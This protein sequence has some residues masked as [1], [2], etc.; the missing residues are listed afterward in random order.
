MNELFKPL[1]MHPDAIKR[2]KAMKK[3]SDEIAELN[4]QIQAATYRFLLLI[5]EYDERGYWNDGGTR[6]CAHW[7]SWRCGIELGA[8]RD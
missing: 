4:A 5:R 6:S 3:L 1:E 2:E 8:A 7:L